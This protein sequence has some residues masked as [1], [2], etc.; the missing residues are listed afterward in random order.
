MDQFDVTNGRM[1]HRNLSISVINRPAVVRGKVKEAVDLNGKGQFVR[2]D[3]R[4]GDVQPCLSN[5]N[6]CKAGATVS[7]WIKPGELSDGM[8]FFSTGTY[9]FKMWQDGG[10]VG[11]VE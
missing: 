6:F 9:G 5:L 1:P 11:R 10:M 4:Q 3:T 7:M 8:E 2:M